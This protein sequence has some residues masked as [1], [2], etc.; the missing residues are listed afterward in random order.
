MTSPG[1]AR[2]LVIEDESMMRALLMEM[3]EAEGYQVESAPDGTAG[4]GIAHREPPDLI[5]CDVQMGGVDGY[6]VLAALRR[7][8]RTAII[9]V[10]FLTGVGGDDAV[11]RGMNLGAD[12]YLVKPVSR[13]LLVGTVRARLSRSAVVR[14]EAARRVEDLRGDL[15]RSLLPHE[16]LTPLTVVMA[17]ASL[18]IEEGAVDA[19]EVKEVAKGILLGAQDLQQMITKFLLYAEIHASGTGKALEEERGVTVLAESARARAAAAGREADIQIHIQSF[20]SPMS[21]EHLQALVDELVENALKFSKPHTTVTISG[22]LEGESCV[23]SVTDQG[24]GMTS[25]QMAGLQHAPFLR[26][27]REQAGLGLGLSIVRRLVDMYDGELAFETAAGSG[28]TVRVRFPG[29]NIPD[30]EA[31]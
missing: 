30:R 8:P 15:A 11:R 23:L 4:L 27:H 29:P 10:I 21:S 1:A 18:L 3:L 2:V 22:G 16:L 31:R 25:D 6:E 28:T 19:A 26:R 24:R 7:D 14:R 20:R 12:D 9:P 5:L 13:E 17:L